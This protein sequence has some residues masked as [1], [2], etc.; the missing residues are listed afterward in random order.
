MGIEVIER[1][2]TSVWALIRQPGSESNLFISAKRFKHF[3]RRRKRM[4]H[5]KTHSKQLH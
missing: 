4:I 3:K 5:A 2:F 1:E